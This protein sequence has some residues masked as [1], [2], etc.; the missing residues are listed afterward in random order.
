MEFFQPP[1]RIHYDR[2]LLTTSDMSIQRIQWE[3]L[4]TELIDSQKLSRFDLKSAQCNSFAIALLK[5]GNDAGE[6]S[7]PVTSGYSEIWKQ[8]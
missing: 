7:H 1:L 6:I 3:R 8:N 5:T 2:R 4:G